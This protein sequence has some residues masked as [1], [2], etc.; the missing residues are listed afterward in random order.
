MTVAAVVRI[1]TSGFVMFPRTT[2]TKPFA[3][4]STPFQ[5]AAQN[6]LALTCSAL[7]TASMTL[8]IKPVTEEQMPAASTRSPR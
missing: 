8:L 7:K 4:A 1:S 3:K 5:S 6:E 2:Y